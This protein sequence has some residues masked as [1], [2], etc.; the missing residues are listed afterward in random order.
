MDLVLNPLSPRNQLKG[1]RTFT[2]WC[3]GIPCLANTN[4]FSFPKQI[5]I[6]IA[7]KCN[8][9]SIEITVSVQSY[10]E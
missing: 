5:M 4:Q 10:P 6:S 9:V 2:L 3:R 8:L 1:K 7:R